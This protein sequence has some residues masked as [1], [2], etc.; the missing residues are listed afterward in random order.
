MKLN[1][2]ISSNRPRMG[3]SKTDGMDYI[4]WSRLNYT[5][6]VEF[7]KRLNYQLM[8]ILL[9]LFILITMN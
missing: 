7:L 2:R 4:H 8:K 5:H 1:T 9:N 3:Y 6:I